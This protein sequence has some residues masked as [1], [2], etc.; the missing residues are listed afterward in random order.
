MIL[1]RPLDVATADT[2]NIIFVCFVLHN[3]W[4]MDDVEVDNML[5]DQIISGEHCTQLKIS[6]INTFTTMA[7]SKVRGTIAEDFSQY[8]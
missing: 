4:E 7:G 5:V 8:L 6:R 3:F 2:A 1:R